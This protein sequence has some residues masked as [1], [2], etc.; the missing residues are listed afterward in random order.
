MVFVIYFGMNLQYPAS[1]YFSQYDAKIE[2]DLGKI[3]KKQN[4]MDDKIKSLSKDGGYTFEDPLIIK[5][6]YLNKL[7]AVVIFN[8]KEETKVEVKINDVHK[9]VMEKSKEHIIPIYGLY[10]G[11][12]NIIS[13]TLD[14]GTTKEHN[15][16]FEAYNDNLTGLETNKVLNGEDLY[17]VVGNLNK[18]DSYLRGFDSSNNLI[19]YYNI[20]YVDGITI[21]K[22]K[23][24]I[25]YN[26]NKD[27]INDLRLDVD[28]LGR[29]SYISS[30]TENVNKKINISNDKDTS[31][32][33]APGYLYDELIANYSFND[34][35]INET[36]SSKSE[37]SLKDYDGKLSS[38]LKYDGDIDIS[39]MGDYISYNTQEDV[40][41]IVVSI[42]G[43]IASYKLNKSGII[44]TNLKGNK[45]LFVNANGIV[46]SLKTTLLDEE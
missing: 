41:L 7:A 46:Y 33:G 11:A 22:N 31:Y 20:K 34:V 36:Y 44:R 35:Q 18:D 39:F 12:T 28:Y 5:S 15:L 30:D 9:T 23:L 25:A 21:N 19:A 32:I 26:Q 45:A 3:L 24:S 4:E 2:N 43:D 40:E 29:I 42:R 8:T 38:A 13:L 16:V 27:L 6:P 37:L 1:K 14:D 17:Y 10:G